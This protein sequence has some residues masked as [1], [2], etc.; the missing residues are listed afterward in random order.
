MR[1]TVIFASVLF[2]VG[3]STHF[4]RRGIRIGLVSVAGVLL[5]AG[6]VAILE[7]PGPPS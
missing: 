2:M 3:I 5:I 6:L 4:G 7:L 1:T